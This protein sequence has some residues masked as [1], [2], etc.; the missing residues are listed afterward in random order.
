MLEAVAL[1][2]VTLTGV[3]FCTLGAASL[4]VPSKANS[5]LRGFASSPRIH[6]MELSIRLLVGAALVIYSPRMVT[7][8]AFSLFGWI[9]LATTIFLFLIPWRWHYRF[10]QQVVPRVTPFIKVIGIFSLAL[11]GFILAAVFRGSAA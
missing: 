7:S 4:F 5:F 11:G 6:Y 10:A 9:L 3:Y 1:I 2:I 8:D